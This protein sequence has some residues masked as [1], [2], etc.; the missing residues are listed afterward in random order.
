MTTTAEDYVKRVLEAIPRATPR[1][2]QIA[3]EVRGHIDERVSHGQS[4]DEAIAQLGDPTVLAESYL[5]AEPLVSAS[6]ID[7]AGAKLVDV[8]LSLVPSL[9]LLIAAWRAFGLD[10]L[11]LFLAAALVGWG[12]LFGLYTIVA[13]YFYGETIGKHL[14]NLVVVRESG[15]RISLGQSF[16]RQ[17][18]ALFE[19]TVLDALFALF[20]RNSQ[21]A[22]ELLSRTRV[23]C[24]ASRALVATSASEI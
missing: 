10:P 24:G 6:F 22:F 4:V 11:P 7:R 1:R 12:L 17:L 8:L 23:V 5:G 18:P 13:E 20:T 9:V 19:L 15:A 16:V 14:F 2:E 3:M 21:R